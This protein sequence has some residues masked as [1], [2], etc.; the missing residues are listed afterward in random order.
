MVSFNYNIAIPSRHIPTW[1]D[2]TLEEQIA[3]L[4]GIERARQAILCR[5]RPDGF[6][7]GINVN[8]AAGQTVFHLHIHVIP[9][10]TRDV[11]DPRG[12]VRNVIP[13]KGNYLSHTKTGLQ[14]LGT[15]PT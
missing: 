5:Y 12:G 11:P 9:R 14:F 3:L 8:L 13:N 4:K 15:I 7:I 1:S 10:Y 6:N 2:A